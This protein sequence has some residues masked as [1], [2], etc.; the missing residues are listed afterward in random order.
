[1]P[2]GPI[3]ARS[4]PDQTYDR[5]ENGEH[6]TDV[7]AIVDACVRAWNDLLADKGRVASLTDYPYLK[8]IR[9]S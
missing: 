9:T 5:Q 7:P 1:S 3:R 4:P 2:P 8:Q 6:V